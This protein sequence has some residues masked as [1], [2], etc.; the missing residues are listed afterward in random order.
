MKKMFKFGLCFFVVSLL[1]AC[2]GANTPTAVTKKFYKA[3]AANDS[4]AM[5]EVATPQT[6][7]LMGMFGSKAQTAMQEQGITD[8]DKLTFVETIDGDKATVTMKTPSGEEG[9]ALDLIKVDGK[10]MVNI[11]MNK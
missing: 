1:V 11:E 8:I 3:V 4:K 5:A 7:E 6:V 10:W 2:A 9:E